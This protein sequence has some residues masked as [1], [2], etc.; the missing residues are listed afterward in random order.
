MT[1]TDTCMMF[2]PLLI[3]SDRRAQCG[4]CTIAA[5]SAMVADSGLLCIMARM[6]AIKWRIWLKHIGRG[7]S[8]SVI[9]LGLLLLLLGYV[10]NR[11]ASRADLRSADALLVLGAAQW[12]GNP[13]PVLEARLNEALRLYRLGYARRIIVAGGTAPNDTRS[14]ASVGYEYLIGRN[15]D[16][17]VLVV[18]A[19]GSD[20]RTTLQAVHAE[21]HPQGIESYLLVTDPPHMLRAL[22]MS[23][24]FGMQ[25]YAAPVAANAPIGTMNS[26]KATWREAWAYLGYVLL[27]E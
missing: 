8:A 3:I 14:E 17:N 24:D 27:N 4:K 19:Q 16:P 12:D 6:Q 21:A 23:H 22:K 5:L 20:T 25:S 2:P 18:V 7:L 10:I 26:L 15:V 11:Q 1:G 9:T 13:S